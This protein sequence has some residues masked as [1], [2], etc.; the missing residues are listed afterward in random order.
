LLSDNAKRLEIAQ[1]AKKS[2]ASLMS[3]EEYLRKYN[4]I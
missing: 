2:S 4:Q 3:K 1:N